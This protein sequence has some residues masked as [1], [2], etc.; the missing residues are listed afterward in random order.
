MFIDEDVRIPL[1]GLPLDARLSMPTRGS[2]VV[3]FAHGGGSPD[4]HVAP[5]LQ[6]EHLAT[7][8]LDLRPDGDADVPVLAG[9]LAA[10]VDWLSDQPT[11]GGHPIGLFGSGV[12]AAVALVVAAERPA[13]VHAVVACGGRADLAGDALT[14]VLAPTLLIVGE[15][16]DRVSHR[17]PSGQVEVVPRLSEEPEALDQVTRSTARWFHR[18]VGTAPARPRTS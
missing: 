1:E 2:G 18:H 5:T 10:V 4:R 17:L 9:R 13:A 6:R 12:D 3:V 14:R 11:T 7:V 15:G 8:L 16:D